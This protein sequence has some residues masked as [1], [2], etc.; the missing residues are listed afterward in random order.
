MTPEL[1]KALR[2][3]LRSSN[4]YENSRPPMCRLYGPRS[5]MDRA[6]IAE[7]IV[8][9]PRSKSHKDAGWNRFRKLLAEAIGAKG[10]CIAELE[11]DMDEKIQAVL[12]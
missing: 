5:V 2:L 4:E 8:G 7:A 11:H 10:G 3:A 12:S 1:V 9:A 6:A